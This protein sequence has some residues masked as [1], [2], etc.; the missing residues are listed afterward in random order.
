LVQSLELH[1]GATVSPAASTQTAD[2][3]QISKFVSMIAELIPVDVTLLALVIIIVLIAI[4]LLVR[5]CYMHRLS[6]PQAYLCVQ[7][8]NIQNC[9]NLEW[10]RL[11]H[12]P[13][14]YALDVKFAQKPG[15][16][17]KYASAVLLA[18]VLKL[19]DIKMTLQHR[20]VQL[21]VDI[22]VKRKVS[23]ALIKQISR[24]TSADYFIAA[25]MKDSKG[26]ITSCF[27]LRPYVPDESQNDRTDFT[28]RPSFAPLYP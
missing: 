26:R 16:A 13:E 8:G 20:H 15:D 9:V 18:R 5:H 17:F 19:T 4:T 7:I 23:R 6:K 22:S 10:A 14:F 11:I 25:V 27:Q 1:Y 21:S 3:A 2:V 24:L 28:S 12:P